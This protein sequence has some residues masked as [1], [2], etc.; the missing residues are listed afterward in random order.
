MENNNKM[1]K[2]NKDDLI[3][4][5]QMATLCF[6]LVYTFGDYLV[7]ILVPVHMAKNVD[8]SDEPEN[9]GYEGERP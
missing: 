2:N 1:K 9:E 7:G 3:I 4:K 5:D 6:L 8:F